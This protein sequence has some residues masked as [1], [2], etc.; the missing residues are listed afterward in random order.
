MIFLDDDDI[1]WCVWPDGTY[2]MDGEYAEMTHLS[3]DYQRVSALAY[4]ADG[5]PIFEPGVGNA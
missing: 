5:T 1:I 3:D 2:C 4:H